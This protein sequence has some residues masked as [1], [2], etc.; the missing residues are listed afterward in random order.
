MTE[1][2]H[3]ADHHEPGEVWETPGSAFESHLPDEPTS[4]SEPYELGEPDHDGVPDEPAGLP[5]E[6][7]ADW[8]AGSGDLAETDPGPVSGWDAHPADLPGP[9]SGL[10]GPGGL[11][12]FGDPADPGGLAD[13]GDPADHGDLGDAGDP[14]DPAAWADGTGIGADPFPPALDMDVTPADGGPWTDPEL[15]G[16][17][18]DDWSADPVT[19]PPAALLPDL[20]AA[21]GDPDASW[22]SLHD[23]D[24]PAVRALAAHWHR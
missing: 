21:D 19:D 7:P 23:S 10:P 18:T 16:G 20:A 8:S 15:I 6:A 22:E 4:L 5:A 11:P 14:A 24:D 3:G 2:D 1:W 9:D 17:G 12:D 13:S